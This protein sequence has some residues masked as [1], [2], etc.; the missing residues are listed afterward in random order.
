VDGRGPADAAPRP[1][2]NGRRLGGHKPVSYLA[3]D[4][5]GIM[6]AGRWFKSAGL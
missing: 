1:G 4:S 6:N 3:A 5:A 2:D